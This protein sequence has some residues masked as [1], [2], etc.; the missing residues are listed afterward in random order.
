MGKRY[1][2]LYNK[3]CNPLNIWW[4]YKAAAKGKRYKPSAATFEYD[5]EENLIEIEQELKDETYQPGGYHSFEIQKPKR[6][7]INAAPFRD[8]VVH[9]ALMNVI[10]LL[11]AQV[12]VISKMT[13]TF[14]CSSLPLLMSI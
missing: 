13:V 10:E 12:T 9:H 2:F 8:R 6:R 5:L 14:L 11:F 7:L 1:Y 4:A 3:I